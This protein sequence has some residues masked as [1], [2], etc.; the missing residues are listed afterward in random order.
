MDLPMKQIVEATKLTPA[1][2][3]RLKKKQASG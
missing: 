3:R 2:I 1:Q